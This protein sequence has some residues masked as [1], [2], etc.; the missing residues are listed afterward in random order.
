MF[1]T[2]LT[3]IRPTHAQ[4]RLSYVAMNG[5]PDSEL[6]RPSKHLRTDDTDDQ[7]NGSMYD[8]E[9]MENDNVEDYDNQ[10]ANYSEES[11][12][13]A[14]KKARTHKLRSFVYQHLVDHVKDQNGRISSAKCIH[15][16]ATIQLTQGTTPA[17]SHLLHHNVVDPKKNTN[18][19][20]TN[21]TEASK[22]Q[23]I[24]LNKQALWV[25]ETAQPFTI[26]ERPSY[27][28]MMKSFQDWMITG[29]A[30]KVKTTINDIYCTSRKKL[31][32]TLI[33]TC[34][35]ISLSLDI[36][37]STDQ[38]PFMAIIGHWLTEEFIYEEA[39]LDF[40]EI[41]GRHTGA[42]M[43][44]YVF[45]C[46][47]YYD[48]QYKLLY[49]VGDNASN[50][51]T[52][53]D[54]VLNKIRQEASE[55]QVILF[56]G[57]DSFIGCLAH[58]LNL[59]VQD[60]LSDLNLVCINKIKEIADHVASQPQRRQ[61]WIK[62]STI[63]DGNRNKFIETNVKTR[64]NS[65]Y[66]MIKDAIQCGDVVKK[67][68]RLD[69]K[70]R[71]NEL[72]ENDWKILKQLEEVLSVFDQLTQIVSEQRPTITQSLGIY[73]RLYDIFDD[74][75]KIINENIPFIKNRHLQELDPTIIKALWHAKD[76][77]NKYY[78]IAISSS[79]YYIGT[80]LDPRRKDKWIRSQL[81]SEGDVQRMIG[82]I[83]SGISIAYQGINQDTQYSHQ[84]DS[85][86]KSSFM[87]CLDDVD[88]YDCEQDKRS[89]VYQYLEE[90]CIKSKDR[91]DVLAWWKEHMIQYPIMSRVARDYLAIPSSSV[92]VER[93]FNFGRDQLGLRRHCM[94]AETLQQLM[95]VQHM[96][97]QERKN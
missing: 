6:E 33:S 34:K 88:S 61:E 62:L 82:K 5:R 85:N 87:L 66:R 84:I 26:V 96:Q 46:L 60:F 86:A 44:E 64:W 52:L 42:N 23:E 25:A 54:E 78:S 89:D 70:L 72:N 1:Q 32:E 93:L 69:D 75:E 30:Y 63:S 94:S 28:E 49:I 71:S 41:Q 7:N 16:N 77:F 67:Y 18:S 91:F 22:L 79:A 20:Q 81:K 13:I 47:K 2:N 29:S 19:D 56:E 80:I 92:S 57:R 14:N 55:E 73:F 39:V 97:R 31:K 12:N 15:C 90:Q 83:I 59:V 50:N 10:T 27:V 17:R 68:T 9:I 65:T 51:G 4:Q 11:N 3:V 35:T 37:T 95:V 74:V 45:D 21:V 76:K 58:T 38:K 48:L 53:M 36:W 40:V 43:A 24:F 8:E